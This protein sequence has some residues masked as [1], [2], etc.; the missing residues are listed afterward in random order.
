LKIFEIFN[1]L[2]HRMSDY[3]FATFYDFMGG[4]TEM[5]STEFFG[6]DYPKFEKV[7]DKY[8]GDYSKKILVRFVKR[9]EEAE[10]KAEPS[11]EDKDKG[12]SPQDAL[13]AIIDCYLNDGSRYARDFIIGGCSMI[14]YLLKK[15][16]TFPTDM[17]FNGPDMDECLYEQFCSNHFDIAAN[18]LDHYGP[19]LNL[20][21]SSYADWGAIEALNW[22]D[23][24]EDELDDLEEDSE[25]EKDKIK[26][27]YL[28]Y[29]SSY[30][31]EKYP[32]PEESE[33]E[34]LAEVKED[35]PAEVKEDI[36]AEVKED[37]P[38]VAKEE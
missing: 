5:L 37:I 23:L 19:K 11:A 30:I 16:A 35:I 21:I 24:E 31:Q 38:E 14:D 8:G 20:D 34:T 1:E 15:G 36:P 4:L 22:E 2:T 29:L 12:V 13:E 7:L 27:A 18:L 26:M 25:A 3:P 6:E 10:A 33:E 17:L 32:D 9:Y 28:K